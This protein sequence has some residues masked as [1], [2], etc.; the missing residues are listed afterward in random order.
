MKKTLFF[1]VAIVASLLLASCSSKEQPVS[2]GDN[3]HGGSS[4]VWIAEEFTADGVKQPFE[5]RG[6]QFYLVMLENGDCL[7]G[8]LA[9]FDKIAMAGKG[10]YKIS[11]DQKNITFNWDNGDVVKYNLVEL[12]MKRLI[13]EEPESQ[14][15]LIFVPYYLPSEETSS[16]G[17]TIQTVDPNE[18]PPSGASDEIL[19]EEE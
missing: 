2:P 5:S 11:D 3:I 15:K 17:A 13:I 10:K 9:Y 18:L 16:D 19:I 4:K 14:M 12:N 8:M 6:D 7:M 1:P